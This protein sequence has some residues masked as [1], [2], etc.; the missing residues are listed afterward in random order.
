MDFAIALVA[1]LRGEAY[2]KAL[3]LQAEYA[4][5][6]PYNAGT[7]ATAP[8]DVGGMMGTMFAPLAVKFRALAMA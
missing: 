7:M 3:M 1:Q 5:V 6:P 8:A 2:A 4:P